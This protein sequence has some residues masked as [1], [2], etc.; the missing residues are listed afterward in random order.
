MYTFPLSLDCCGTSMMHL[1]CNKASKCH[2]DSALKSN[3]K[4]SEAA[5]TQGDT[6]DNCYPLTKTPGCTRLSNIPTHS[7]ISRLKLD[8]L[9]ATSHHLEGGGSTTTACTISADLSSPVHLCPTF[10]FSPSVNT[11]ET[12]AHFFLLT[13]EQNQREK[14][15][16]QPTTAQK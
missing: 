10:G 3:R 9:T 11:T 1:R 2:K 12:G 4:C 5:D 16:N 6:V 13:E 15:I 8:Y 14:K 7:N